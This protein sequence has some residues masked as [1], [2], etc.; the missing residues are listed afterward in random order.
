VC[1]CKRSLYAVEA[2]ET[3]EWR[4][5]VHF[6]KFGRRTEGG[7]AETCVG[8]IVE[9]VTPPEFNPSIFL[10]PSAGHRVYF[11]GK[12]PGEIVECPN[13]TISGDW[14]PVWAIMMQKRGKG[15]AVYC[16]TDP[17]NETPG[18]ASCN[19]QKRCRLWKKI[20]WYGRKRI[21]CPSH[22]TLR[23]L[24]QRYKEA[25]QRVS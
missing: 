7:A 8:S 12:N 18:R 25:A 11:I 23:A 4:D 24:W 6:D 10:P 21:A 16:G 13:E 20:L 15:I 19:N 9:G 17:A 5:A 3:V 1:I 22:P 14:Q 2:V